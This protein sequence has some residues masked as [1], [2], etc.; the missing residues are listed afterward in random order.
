MS[1]SCILDNLLF[2][3]SG[4]VV[5]VS[6]VDCVNSP[7]EYKA[8]F[9]CLIAPFLAMILSSFSVILTPLSYII[10]LKVVLKLN[11]KQE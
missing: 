2:S 5:T 4:F 3:L 1:Y 10:S 11:L 8:V 9:L 6:N 7:R